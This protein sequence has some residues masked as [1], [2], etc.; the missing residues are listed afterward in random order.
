VDVYSFDPLTD[1]RWPDFAAAHPDASIFHQRQWLAALRRT[2]GYRP[3][4][5]TSSSSAAAL[6]DALVM[7][8]VSSWLTGTR[9][10]SVPF[11]DHCDPLVDEGCSADPLLDAVARSSNQG[12]GA[13]LEVRPHRYPPGRTSLF[14]PAARYTLHQID[15]APSAEQL[16]ARF[17]KNTIQRNIR[18]AERS[19]EYQADNT[20]AFLDRFY[21]L[22]IL[23]RRRH[24]VPPQPRS[25]FKNLAEG[26]GERLRI[27][28]ALSQGHAVAAI[29]AIVHGKTMVYKYGASDARAHHL[30]SM[31]FLFW[32]LIR[33]AKSKDLRTLDLGRSE[34]DNEGLLTFKTRLGGVAS[35]LTYYRDRSTRAGSLTMHLSWVHR[36]AERAPGFV[37]TAAGRLL[38]RHIG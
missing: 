11:A 26:F 35:P 32:Q 23:T 17:H 19:L 27:H 13:Y 34:N 21:Q 10:V 2:Y 33:E 25:W 3:L 31:P 1:P 15:L 9:L 22:L 28:L 38:Y 5:L 20:P 7:C 14:A 29:L 16:F 8:Q 18:R 4:G 6:R 36:A 37:L 12:L 24:G 30:G